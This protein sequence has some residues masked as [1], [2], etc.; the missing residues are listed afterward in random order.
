MNRV[1][2]KKAFTLRGSFSQ[3]FFALP[4]YKQSL[5]NY[6]LSSTHEST[7]N[8]P[9]TRLFKALL[10]WFA[11]DTSTRTIILVLCFALLY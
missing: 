8:S 10:V 3:G 11:M 7:R 4:E 1:L 2:L 9:D 5:T 6:I